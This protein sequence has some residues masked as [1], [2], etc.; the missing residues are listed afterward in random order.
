MCEKGTFSQIRSH[1]EL[2]DAKE[3]NKMSD[4]IYLDLKKAFDTVSHCKLLFKLRSY[5]IV[6]KLFN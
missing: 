2:L 3:N 5:G 6:G 1:N 4:V